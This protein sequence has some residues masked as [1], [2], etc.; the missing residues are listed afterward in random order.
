MNRLVLNLS[1]CFMLLTPS[2]FLAQAKDILSA[3]ENAL[4]MSQADDYIDEIPEGQQDRMSDAL[5]HSLRGMQRELYSFRDKQN[6][7]VEKNE[8]V[9][10]KE[11]YVDAH[12]GKI[13]TLLYSPLTDNTAPLP[14]VVFLHGGGWVFGSSESFSFFCS[15]LA[16]AAN[17]IVLSPDY[18]LAP[19]NPYPTAFNDCMAIM[20]YL[21]KNAKDLGSS[22]EL[23]SI[24][25]EDAGGNLALY[26][27]QQLSLNNESD[28]RLNSLIL[29]YPIISPKIEK[30]ESWKK[31]SR[32]Y[33]FDGRLFEA[34]VQAYF[35]DK[36]SVSTD[37]EKSKS[38]PGSM[39]NLKTMPPILFISAGRDMLFDQGKE[40]TDHLLSRKFEVKRIDF[41]GAVHGFISIPGQPAA[42]EKAIM[43]TSEF[44]NSNDKRN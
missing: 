22:P 9:L 44:L 18:P 13:K 33:G 34:C 43:I 27:A 36:L 37:D 35:Q 39:D 21:F 10:V 32:G 5:L 12:S 31:Y 23:I 41:P 28:H 17:V 7:L 40:F 11:L 25:G 8:D 15:E 20:D 19:E 42:F 1:V 29:F 30:T 6:A 16:C 14:I 3:E 2:P 38:A 24:A 26:V 4:M